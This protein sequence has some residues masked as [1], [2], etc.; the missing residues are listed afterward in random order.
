M[1]A[2]KEYLFNVQ[3]K[4]GAGDVSDVEEISFVVDYAALGGI[5]DITP[6]GYIRQKNVTVI[7]ET[8]KKALCE[9]KLYTEYVA[10]P[11]GSEY[12]YS[13]SSSRHIAGEEIQHSYPMFHRRT[14]TAKQSLHLRSIYRRLPS[15]M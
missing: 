3:C 2:R 13:F 7:V 6:K 5:V 12:Q 15:K 9:Y 1:G 4:N 8:S 10:F 14:L 11:F